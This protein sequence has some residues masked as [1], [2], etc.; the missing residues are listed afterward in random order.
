MVFSVLTILFAAAISSAT[1]NTMQISQADSPLDIEGAFMGCKL[2][3]CL[4]IRVK[5]VELCK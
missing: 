1:Q 3:T 5:I 4:A 2:D